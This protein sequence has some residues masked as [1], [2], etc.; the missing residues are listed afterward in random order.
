MSEA[1]LMFTVAWVRF[2]MAAAAMLGR[3]DIELEIE[4]Q[5]SITRVCRRKCAFDLTTLHT[6]AF[7]AKSLLSGE[8]LPEVS[9]ELLT[10]GNIQLCSLLMTLQQHNLISRIPNFGA[11]VGMAC[12]CICSSSRSDCPPPHEAS[13]DAH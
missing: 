11:I 13:G 2:S 10:D 7:P 8:S 6:T 5:D 1:D 12:K 9:N 4:Y 3:V